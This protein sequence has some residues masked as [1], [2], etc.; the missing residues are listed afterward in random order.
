MDLI[1][2]LGVNDIQHNDTQHNDSQHNDTRHTDTRHND[3]QHTDTQHTDTQHYNT[4]QNDTQ[5]ND[6]QHNDTQRNDSHHNDTQH[7]DTWPRIQCLLF[8][9]YF[10]LY[11]SEGILVATRFK[12]QWYV[13][14]IKDHLSNRTTSFRHQC[15][16]TT[17]LSNHRCLI[18]N[19]VEK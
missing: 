19:G 3:T 1:V 10:I 7:K 17:V 4:H 18:N 13:Y 9:I 2:A 8:Q 5:H 15:K 12:T 14:K 11:S 16:N 6:T